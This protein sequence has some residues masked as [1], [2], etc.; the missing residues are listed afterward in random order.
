MP[1][2]DVDNTARLVLSPAIQGNVRR[3]ASVRGH[4]DRFESLSYEVLRQ[5]VSRI[6]GTACLRRI[7]NLKREKHLHNLLDIARSRTNQGRRAQLVEY[8]R[9]LLP[10][11]DNTVTICGSTP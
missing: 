8:T 7:E 1:R 5:P 11:I 4:N 10:S 3:Q 6:R 2:P 9:S